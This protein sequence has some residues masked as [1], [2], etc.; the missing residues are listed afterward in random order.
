MSIF[1]NDLRVQRVSDTEYHLPDDGGHWTVQL[2]DGQW[3][4]Y[5]QV[6]VGYDGASS[7]TTADDAIRAIIGDPQ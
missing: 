4:A 5:D 1:K 7:K 2:E 3:N 6:S